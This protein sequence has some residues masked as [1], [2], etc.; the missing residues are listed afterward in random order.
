[1]TNGSHYSAQ[2]G[3]LVIFG[4]GPGIGVH[5]ASRFARGGF[6]K[7]VLLSRNQRR[8]SDDA[9]IV[10]SNAPQVQVSTITVDLTVPADLDRALQEI[11]YILAGT[12]IECVHY[13]R[14]FTGV[15]YVRFSDIFAVCLTVHNSSPAAERMFDLRDNLIVNL[16]FATNQMLVERCKDLGDLAASRICRRPEKEPRAVRHQSLHGCSMGNATAPAT[17]RQ[18]RVQAGAAGDER[19][20]RS[21]AG[22][23]LLRAGRVQICAAER[24]R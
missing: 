13:G 3:A 16:S 18:A 1:M 9:F 14:W 10:Y 4:S 6:E 11:E 15:T 19:L 23:K 21:C 12:P 5:V 17:R 2:R 8:L 20:A 7:I 24:R 22:T